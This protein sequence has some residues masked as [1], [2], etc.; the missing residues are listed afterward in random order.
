[1][2]RAVCSECGEPA[3]QVSPNDWLPAWG[4]A[5]AWSHMDGSALCPVVGAN[6]YEP[7]QPEFV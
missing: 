6:G 5:P 4:S 2:S 1:M 3:Q 7:A